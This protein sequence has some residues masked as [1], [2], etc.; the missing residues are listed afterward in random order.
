MT[1]RLEELSRDRPHISQWQCYG[2][3]TC[4]L[5]AD[6]RPQSMLNLLEIHD[7]TREA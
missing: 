1:I 5:I 7:P 3:G 6:G 2:N 4:T